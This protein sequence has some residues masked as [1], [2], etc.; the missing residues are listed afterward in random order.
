MSLASSRRRSSP[1]A[2]TSC[3][4]VHLPPSRRTRAT[5]RSPSGDLVPERQ[6]DLCRSDLTDGDRR[7]DGVDYLTSTLRGLGVEGRRIAGDL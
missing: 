7:R 4:S 6:R 5:E 3:H 1:G 2:R